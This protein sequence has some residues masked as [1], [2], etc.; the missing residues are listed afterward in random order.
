MNFYFLIIVFLYAG[1]SNARVVPLTFKQDKSKHVDSSILGNEVIDESPLHEVEILGHSLPDV[2]QSN[3]L[4]LSSSEEEDTTVSEISSIKASSLPVDLAT[5][6]KDVTDESKPESAAS[7]EIPDVFDEEF[8]SVSEFISKNH[9]DSTDFFEALQN[10]RSLNDNKTEDLTFKNETAITNISFSLD[11]EQENNKD[12][13]RTEEKVL[14]NTLGQ[15]ETFAVSGDQ[16]KT[17]AAFEISNGDQNETV[18][19]F[20]ISN[21]DQNET[22]AASE[23]S[24]GDQ[25]KT[26]AV[27]EVTNSDQNETFAIFKIV[28][29]TNSSDNFP[30]LQ[31]LLNDTKLEEMFLSETENITDELKNFTSE[32]LELINDSAKIAGGILSGFDFLINSEVARN[33]AKAMEVFNFSDPLTDH[34]IE[35]NEFH[36]FLPAFNAGHELDSSNQR[37]LETAIIL[38][39]SSGKSNET[40][41]DFNTSLPSGDEDSIMIDEVE[42]EEIKKGSSV[43]F[44]VNELGGRNK[45]GLTHL[46][47]KFEGNVS[48]EGA[49]SLEMSEDMIQLAPEAKPTKQKINVS[50]SVSSTV[51]TGGSPECP[52]PGW[53]IFWFL[54]QDTCAVNEHCLGSRICCKIRCSKTCIEI[55]SL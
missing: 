32:N 37:N 18:T 7:L 16:N 29:G 25:D 46:T 40:R 48:S 45:T 34:I 3:D 33:A 6:E 12:V 11:L 28:N 26:S 1:G 5:K 27:S 38:T 52:P 23:N 41:T 20:E 55:E 47:E 2:K 51:D 17:V 8:K 43:P 22:F 21:G 24:N 30:E 13:V 4:D 19:A 50:V 31:P 36:S 9:L 35:E 10:N 44:T 15:S 53:C 49:A 14:N 39:N 42:S 54:S